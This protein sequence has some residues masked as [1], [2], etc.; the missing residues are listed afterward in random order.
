MKGKN[1]PIGVFDSGVGGLTVLKKIA[2]VLPNENYI[3]FGDTARIPYGEKTKEQLTEFVRE[4]LNWYRLKN[5]KMVLMAC[6]TSSAVV[7]DIVKNEYDFPI[8]GLIQPTAKKIAKLEAKKVAIIATSAT[9]K[10]KAYSKAILE[11][12]KDKEIFEIACPGLV[13]IVEKDLVN[14]EEGKNLVKK[15]IL[16]VLENQAEKIV[17]GCTHYPYLTDIINEITN[18]SGMLI[19]PADFLAEEARQELINFDLINNSSAGL[20]KYFVSANPDKFVEVGKKF[21]ANCVYAEVV[22]LNKPD[23][24]LNFR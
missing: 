10:S 14:S 9:F 20:I 19:N 18:N 24:T 5:S 12:N 6:N 23:K 17:L 1:R 2:E 4:I 11:L 22:C 13:E 15:Y 8:L 21:Y 16:P 7:L 3:Y